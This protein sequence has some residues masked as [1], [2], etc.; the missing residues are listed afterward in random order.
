M[1]AVA[2]QTWSYYI[3]RNHSLKFKLLH[4]WKRREYIRSP[5]TNNETRYL[6]TCALCVLDVGNKQRKLLKK[7]LNKWAKI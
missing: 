2:L 7:W 5:T 4:L 3:K 1:Q 6:R